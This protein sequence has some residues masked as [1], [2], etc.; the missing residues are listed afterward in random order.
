MSV[1]VSFLEKTSAAHVALIR[2]VAI[3]NVHVFLQRITEAESLGANRTLELSFAGMN[4][5]MGLY[6]TSLLE[7]FTANFA[8]KLAL[9]GVRRYV[10]LQNALSSKYFFA[11]ITFEQ[12]IHF[13]RSVHYCVSSVGLRMDFQTV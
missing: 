7:P 11:I 10:P 13:F 1:Q 4:Q 8:A 9:V 2:F 3:V 6:V 5:H 12:T